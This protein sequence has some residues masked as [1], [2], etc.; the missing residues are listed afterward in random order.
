MTPQSPPRSAFRDAAD[1]LLVFLAGLVLLSVIVV[2]AL[3]TDAGIRLDRDVVASFEV[4]E[5]R[6]GRISALLQEIRIPTMLLLTL[7]AML[8]VLARRLWRVALALPLLVIGANQTTQL[9]K[10]R[11]L[12][13]MPSDPAVRVSMPS[14]HSTAAISLAA[15]AIIAAPRILRPLVCL[16]SGAIAGGAGLGTMAER[17]HKPADVIAAVGVVLIWAAVATLIGARWVE[18]PQ[19][20][21]AGLDRTVGHSALAVLGVAAGAF[22]LHRLGM[23]PVP[24]ARAATLVY[25]SLIVVG[26]TIGLGLGLIAVLADRRL[27]RLPRAVAEPVPAVVTGPHTTTTPHTATGPHTTTRPHTEGET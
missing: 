10:L 8:V 17:W 26:L 16:L 1:V 14:G 2:L 15:V 18:P 21:P 13:D 6:P 27:W 7:I 19:V 24:G 11:F 9:L 12:T 25:A 4:D 20:R 5:F 23:G 3:R 22:V